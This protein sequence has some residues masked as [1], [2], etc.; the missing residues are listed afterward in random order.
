MNTEKGIAYGVLTQ[1]WGRSKKP[2]AFL[3]KLL[4]PVARGWPTCLHAIAA[5]AILLEE[6]QKLTL[7]GKIRIHTP[8]DL[9]TI[10][11]HKAQQ[12]LTDSRILKYEIILMN[13]ENLVLNTSKSLNPAQFLSGE[14]L[15]NLE[16][17]CIELINLQTKV[18]EDLEDTPLPYRRVLFTD[19]SSRVI[20]GKRASGYAIIEGTDVKVAER[21]KLPSNWSAQ[22]CEICTLK[23][24]L[25]LL[26]KDQ[27]TIYTN[28]QHAFGII[29]TFGKIWEEQGYLNS[30]GKSL[31]H[32]ELIKLILESLYKPAEIA[33]V[34]IKGPQKADTF[35]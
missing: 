23:R 24:R 18:R 11:S 9:K 12:W 29:H 15:T 34:H 10:L 7:Q 6:A 20:E 14:P 25:D 32:K 28:S 21:G 2:V 1:E 31:V 13:S 22:C 26:E 27:G 8:C 4:D 17:D 5:T 35:E 30:K 19:G 33:V 3:S 16:H